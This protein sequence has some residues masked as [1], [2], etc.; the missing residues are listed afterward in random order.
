MFLWAD[1]REMVDASVYLALQTVAGLEVERSDARETQPVQPLADK[2]VEQTM[3]FLPEV[4]A[5]VAKL[6]WLL[7]R[8]ITIDGAPLCV[9]VQTNCAALCQVTC[10][11]SVKSPNPPG[12]LR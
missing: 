7:G 10:E 3:P 5:D 9:F 11:E 4:V 2:V 12:Q 8:T 6:Q 1:S